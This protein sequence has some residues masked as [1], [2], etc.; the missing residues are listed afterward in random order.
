M[1]R[2]ASAVC[3]GL[4]IGAGLLLRLVPWGLP[5]PVHHYGGGLLWG[6][7][8]YCLAAAV[9][10]GGWDRGACAAVAGAVAAAIEFTRLVHTPELDAFRATLAGQLALGRIFSAWNLLAYAGGIA[11]AAALGGRLRRVLAA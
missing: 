9:R 11:A 2:G 7:M 1:S 8:L 10:P 3:A 5:L 4:V 6:A